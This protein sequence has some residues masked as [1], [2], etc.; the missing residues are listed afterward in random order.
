MKEKEKKE[1]KRKEWKYIENRTTKECKKW[2]KNQKEKETEQHTWS[3]I[4]YVNEQ[5][6]KNI[7]E[8]NN[9]KQSSEGRNQSEWPECTWAEPIYLLVRAERRHQYARALAS[10]SL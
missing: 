7:R 8:R 9:T 4:S 6:K 5:V 2:E 10:N 3:G 1:T